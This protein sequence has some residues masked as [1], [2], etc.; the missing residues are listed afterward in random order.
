[1]YCI[2]TGYLVAEHYS[3]KNQANMVQTNNGNIL[4]HNAC[5][6]NCSIAVPIERIAL[7]Q[8]KSGRILCILQEMSCMYWFGLRQ[9]KF[10]SGKFSCFHQ[11]EGWKIL[12]QVT[13]FGWV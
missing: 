8:L 13:R 3:G 5:H 11:V 1:M 9:A 6:Q 7:G 2:Q 4:N 10:K 12:L